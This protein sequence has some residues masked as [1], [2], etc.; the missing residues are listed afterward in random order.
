VGKRYVGPYHML[1]GT[2]KSVDF[3]ID[4]NV[5]YEYNVKVLFSF[6]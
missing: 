4:V 3:E 5:N 1:S 2:F 6:K